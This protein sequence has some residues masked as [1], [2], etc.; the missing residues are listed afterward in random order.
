MTYNKRD[1]AH[2]RVI[3]HSDY[4]MDLVKSF[5]SPG[6]CDGVVELMKLDKRV[7][8]IYVDS[9][10]SKNK[11]EAIIESDFQEEKDCLKVEIDKV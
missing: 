2:G 1:K 7:V 9:E 11:I 5:F 3:D 10:I 4:I 6:F 8:V